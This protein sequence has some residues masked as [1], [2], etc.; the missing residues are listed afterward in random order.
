[1]RTSAAI[2]VALAVI[3][4]AVYWPVAGHEFLNY[5]DPRDIYE[6]PHITGADSDGGLTAGGLWWALTTGDNSN[7]V[8]LTR[9]SWMIDWRL[10]RD[11]SQPHGCW[12]GGH[13][14]VDAGL[15][16]AGGIVLFL[17]LTWMT[18]RRWPSAFV[19][20]MF[21]VHPLHVESVAWAV[22]R[23]DTLSGLFWM[24]TLA[25][26]AWYVRRPGVGRYALVFAA[27]AL[28]LM[29]KPMLVTLPLVLL[30]L[31]W[32]PLGRMRG[33]PLPAVICPG[34]PELPR[35]Q[36]E[37]VIPSERS[38]SRNLAAGHGRDV[39]MAAVAST[40]N[41]RRDP[42]T[43]LGVTAKKAMPK[44]PGAPFLRLIVEKLPLLAL[45]VASCIV[46]YAV[47]SAGGAVAGAGRLLPA[48]RIAN[49][50]VACVAYLAKAAAPVNLAIFYP[51]D[52]RLPW[53]E[54]AGAAVLLAAATVA[55]A[56][57][58]RRRPYVAVGWF[59]FLGTLVPVIG[60]VQVGV[61]SMADRY[62]YIP[63]IGIFMAAAWGARDA[64]GRLR[65]PRWALPAAGAAVIGACMV[66]AFMQ[67]R[68]WRD[69]ESIFRHALRATDRNWQAHHNLGLAL[70]TQGRTNE[71]I[72]EFR[73]ATLTKPEYPG[74]HY[75][76]GLNLVATGHP[77]KAIG[78][79]RTL[80][81]L[82]PQMAEAHF[83]LGVA[84]AAVGR[85]DEAAAAYRAAIDIRP[86]FAEAH[87][88]L[89]IVLADLGDVDGAIREH[90]EAIRINPDL[91]EA[92]QN[93]AGVL[94][95]RDPMDDES[96]RQFREVL[97][98]RP[99]CAE[100]YHGIGLVLQAR[101]QVDE[102]VRQFQEALRLKP[103]FKQA[104]QALD[105]I[106]GPRG[107]AVPPAAP[108]PGAPLPRGGG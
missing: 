82:R 108:S 81:A 37:T 47:Q 2:C 17:A 64:A 57:A 79:Y 24:L 53:D 46:T 36:K 3:T 38:E 31:D 54:V 32:W 5:D 44:D 52:R 33:G 16:A 22:E 74:S 91:L 96:I 95:R 10:F 21:L 4:A 39:G 48:E 19:A 71:A 30:L 23:K 107:Q 42:S 92:H 7:W 9:L 8:P 28:G 94:M 87:T 63:M 40:R 90:R 6:N 41:A 78:E 85:K 15:H 1:M 14:L 25:A 101:G 58:A 29:A 18:G 83:N 103:D 84:L 27:L 68:H 69:S 93:L 56:L 61:Q 12:A 105:N 106:L 20:A 80:I 26:Y 88:N 76:L 77:D 49:A 59:W 99:T 98:I 102:A 89:G 13:H 97:R 65:L 72:D 86:D 67:V 100:A 50:V 75:Q 34:A 45:S 104:Q 60:L 43:S 55:A 51:Y 66:A 11:P 70:A 35:T 73:K 62:T